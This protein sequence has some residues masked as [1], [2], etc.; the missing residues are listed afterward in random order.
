M[1]IGFVCT[2]S[3]GFVDASA[4][5]G[6]FPPVAMLPKAASIVL[7]Y[8][9]L[10]L[11]WHA[12]S[13]SNFNGSLKTKNHS[14]ALAGLFRKIVIPALLIHLYILVPRRKVLQ[15]HP[16]DVL[17][18]ESSARAAAWTKQANVSRN[19]GDAVAQYHGRYGRYP[20]LASTY[21]THSRRIDRL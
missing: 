19:I 15:Y 8:F 16:I 12:A 1:L 4:T 20:P 9:G 2:S 17:I 21:G 14:L 5:Q 11:I 6:A 10:A 13:I 18:Q 3:I 7:S